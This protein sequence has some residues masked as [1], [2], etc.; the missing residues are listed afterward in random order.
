MNKRFVRLYVERTFSMKFSDTSDF[1]ME[2]WKPLF[3]YISYFILPLSL[4]EGVNLSGYFSSVMSMSNGSN[5]QD[6]T[7]INLFINFG[8]LVVLSFMASV[9]TSGVVYALMKVYQEREERLNGL[10]MSILKPYLVKSMKKSAA[11]MAI[12][13]LSF[14]LLFVIDCLLIAVHPVLFFLGLI[15]LLAIAVPMA[16]ALPMVQF[17]DITVVAAIRKSFVYGFKTWGGIFALTVI[18]SMITGMV[19]GVFSIPMYILIMLKSFTEGSL[20]SSMG[21]ISNSPWYTALTY[22]SST[23]YIYVYQLGASIM[24]VGL[25]YQYGHAAAKIG[26]K[27]IEESVDN[28]EE[29]GVDDDGKHPERDAEED[30]IDRAFKEI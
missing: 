8:L 4:V 12:I 7:I 5:L 16:L 13:I 30:A 24:L 2:N 9:A 6:N 23:A 25:A 3:R 20:D 26:G 29:L 11:V 27:G 1:I 19:C 18:I 28:F 17:E 10:T 21:A 22:L 14:C 15:A